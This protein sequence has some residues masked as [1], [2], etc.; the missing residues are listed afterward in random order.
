MGFFRRRGFQDGVRGQKPGI[1]FDRLN[2]DYYA[3][4]NS[5]YQQYLANQ[6]LA[7]QLSQG[8]AATVDGVAQTD[9]RGTFGGGTQGVNLPGPK[10][11][12]DG[13]LAA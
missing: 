12:E 3:G 7:D 8:E 5:G 9:E 4:K 2:K 13:A 1:I 11:R 10:R 6:N